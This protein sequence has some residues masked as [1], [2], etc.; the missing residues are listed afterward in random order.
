MQDKVTYRWNTDIGLRAFVYSCYTS[1]N[2]IFV[3][4]KQRWTVRKFAYLDKKI[5]LDL[6]TFRK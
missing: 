4:I 2:K 6:R 5:F 1:C 3:V